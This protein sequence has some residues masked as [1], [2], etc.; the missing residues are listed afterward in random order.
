MKKS[1]SRPSAPQTPAPTAGPR[2]VQLGREHW[3]RGELV[4]ATECAQMALRHGASPRDAYGLL[5]DCLMGLR[6]F[7]P[8]FDAYNQA[9]ALDISNASLRFLCG[10][11]LFHC[12][13]Y[14]AVLYYLKDLDPGDNAALQIEHAMTL[15][16]AQ[17]KLGMLDQA[18]LN[19]LKAFLLQ[20]DNE[21]AVC[22]L[23]ALFEQDGRHAL[24]IEFL[25]PAVQKHPTSVRLHYNL[26]TDFI[27]CGHTARG[28]AC[29]RDTLRLAPQHIHAHQNL[30]LAL[31]AHGE[32]T[33]GW[34]HYAWRSNRHVAEGGHADWV[35]QTHALP[36]D[37][38]GRT[39]RVVGEQGIGDELFFMRYLPTLQARGA[40][41]Q[42]QPCNGKLRPLLS[43][44]EHAI[45]TVDPATPG[46]PADTVLLA[47]D[48]PHALG[49]LP[50]SQYPA[51]VALRVDAAHALHWQHRSALLSHPRPRLGIAWRAGTP[52][53][54]LPDDQQQ[55]V[56]FKSVPLDALLDVLVPLPVDLVILQRQASSDELAYVT[57]RVGAD[58]MLD[59]SR[60][61]NDLPDLLALLSL[62][63]GLVGVSN[64]N[65]HLAAGLATPLYTL[66]PLPYEF[67]WQIQGDASPWFPGSK[68][69]RQQLDGGWEAPLARL[70][71]DLQQRFAE[72]PLRNGP[73]A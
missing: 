73:G 9:L 59:A 18:E 72:A 6:Q 66:V 54:P 33:E 27:E 48:L 20:P 4:Q 44:M 39:V 56:L 58:R 62:L 5:G 40:S 3:Q 19:L 43:H 65:V 30:A 10:E 61:D 34:L 12:G 53:L 71:T 25:E 51:P 14:D 22:N 69:Y 49:V 21:D 67:R 31:L 28:I 60:D 13:R 15:G 37:L 17:Q 2:W 52:R 16:R 7:E 55:R 23:T 47:G 29:M 35:P 32:L 57:Q 63:D 8:A 24:A 46:A 36:L 1:R 50:A 64:T 68:V 26:G 11:A 38:T 41:L 70:Q 42:Y 45:P